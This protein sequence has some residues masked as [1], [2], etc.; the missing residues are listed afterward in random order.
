MKT[1]R[2]LALTLLAAF[3][4]LLNVPA[5]QAESGETIQINTNSYAAVAFSRSTN[6]YHYAH[7]YP[8]RAEA[9]QAAL[10][11]LN[12]GDG[13]LAGW[14]KG[15]FFA[16]A[17]SYDGGWRTG[18]SYGEAASNADAASH[19]LRDFRAQGRGARIVV[20]LSSDGQ[21]IYKR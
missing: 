8:S 6:R 16:L 2:L 15:G 13:K 19:A 20:C 4:A 3:A 9:E 18:W 12:A 1:F 11:G 10:R 21:Y 17:F 7:N 14:V 5:A